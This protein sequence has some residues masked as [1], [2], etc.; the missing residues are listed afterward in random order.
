[1]T[2]AVIINRILADEDLLCCPYVLF[3]GPYRSAMKFQKGLRNTTSSHL[4]IIGLKVE[5]E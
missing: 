5:E 4:S 1:M 2:K 3:L